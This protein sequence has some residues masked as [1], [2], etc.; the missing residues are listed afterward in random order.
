MFLRCGLWSVFK[1]SPKVLYGVKVDPLCK[2]HRSSAS[3]SENKLL[4]G[5][6]NVWF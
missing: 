5:C 2:Q 4:L 1:F 6:H 3:K